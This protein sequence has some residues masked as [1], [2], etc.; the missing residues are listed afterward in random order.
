MQ[1]RRRAR[2]IALE[3][4]YEVDCVGHPAAEVLAERLLDETVT[5]ATAAFAGQLVHGVLKYQVLM[6]RL[7]ASYAPEWPV[8]QMALIDRNVLRMAIYELAVDSGTPIRVAINEAVELAKLYGSDSSARFIN[9]VLGTLVERIDA[10]RAR[11]TAAD[12]DH[13][14]PG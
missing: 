10:I 6:D 5:P 14:Q 4:L 3:A 1:P 2:G 9:G 12:L 7:I 8:E 11:L 13:P